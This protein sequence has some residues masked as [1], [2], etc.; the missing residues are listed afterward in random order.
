MR[1]LIEGVMPSEVFA[2][3]SYDPETREV[4]IQYGYALL[5]LPLEDFESFLEL[6]ME[7]RESLDGKPP[8]KGEP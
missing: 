3:V 7:A 5:S 1:E 8:R 4:G 6:L 2:A